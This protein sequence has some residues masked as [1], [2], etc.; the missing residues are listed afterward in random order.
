M[1]VLL[2]TDESKEQHYTPVIGRSPGVCANA[3]LPP[4]KRN[5]APTNSNKVSIRLQKF[6]HWIFLSHSRAV[7]IC[8][9]LSHLWDCRYVLMQWRKV[10]EGRSQSSAFSPH[11]TPE[12][13]LQPGQVWCEQMWTGHDEG[14]KSA[15]L[16]QIQF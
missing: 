3:V 6:P 16:T 13:V 14:C 8:V 7:R 4:I 15:F 2:V 5:T 10:L 12:K 1:T 9:S 11:C